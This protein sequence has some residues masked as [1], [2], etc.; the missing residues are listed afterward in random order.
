MRLV[1][2]AAA[3]WRFRSLFPPACTVH[4]LLSLAP[5][6]FSPSTFSFVFTLPLLICKPIPDLFA[7][8]QERFFVVWIF[9]LKRGHFLFVLPRVRIKFIYLFSFVLYFAHWALFFSDSILFLPIVPQCLSVLRHFVHQF[10]F[11]SLI[12]GSHRLSL[13]QALSAAHLYVFNLPLFSLPIPFVFSLSPLLLISL[14]S[15]KIN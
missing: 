7:S 6:S 14:F 12:L 5:R 11:I 9:G 4:V 8:S 13:F 3:C 10:A 2:A 1:P 15:L